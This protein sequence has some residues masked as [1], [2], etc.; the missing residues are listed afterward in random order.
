MD[1]TMKDCII[2]S[3]QVLASARLNDIL[4]QSDRIICADGGASHARQLGILPDLLIGDF[5]SVADADL[6][7]FIQKNIPVIRYPSDKNKTDTQLC[8]EWALDHG[9]TDITLI[10]ATGTR[11]DHTLANIFLLEKLTCR[12]INARIVDSHNEI[13]VVTQKLVLDGRPGE[14]L[15]ILPFGKEAE[16][17]SLEGLQYPLE[18]AVIKRGTSLG[19][20]NVF[21]SDQAVIKIKNGTLL[22]IRSQD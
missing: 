20:S 7:Y 21:T 18:N 15:S 11:L 22:V 17:V 12:N 8:I 19:I 10:G 16:G 13:H 9:T 5:D 2:A 6:N 4:K 3:G 14:L 1:N